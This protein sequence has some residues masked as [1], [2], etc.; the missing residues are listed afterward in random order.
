MLVLLSYRAVRRLTPLHI[1]NAS[2]SERLLRIYIYFLTVRRG[3]CRGNGGSYEALAAMH[4]KSREDRKNDEAAGIL[5]TVPAAAAAAAAAE[6]AWAAR[7]RRLRAKKEPCVLP[8]RL[9]HR[10]RERGRALQYALSKCH[11][12]LAP[13]LRDLDSLNWDQTC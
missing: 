13:T 5:P 4:D 9:L 10:V 8:D 2:A 12:L 7:A 3:G 6:R 1:R 11:R